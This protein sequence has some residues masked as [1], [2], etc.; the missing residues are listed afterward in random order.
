MADNLQRRFPGL[1]V[2]GTHT[3]PFR[4]LTDEEDERVIAEINAASPD[5]VW[6]GLSTLKQDAWMAMH[7][8]QLE[9]PVLLSVGAAFDFHTGNLRRAPRW[10]Q[11]LSLEWLLRLMMEPK[12]LWRRY[13][14]GNTL[15][16]LYLMAEVL[17]IRQVY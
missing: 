4:P 12:R 6:V 17:R 15:F 1:Q 2:A 7:Q 5:F 11:H 14:V 8:S 9:A 13:L 16:A 10:V 3:P